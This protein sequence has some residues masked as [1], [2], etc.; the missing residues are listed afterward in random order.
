MEGIVRNGIGRA[1]RLGEAHDVCSDVIGQHSN[2]QA[3]ADLGAISH[4]QHGFHQVQAPKLSDVT[5]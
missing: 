4:A 2:L 5:P 1:G 3:H